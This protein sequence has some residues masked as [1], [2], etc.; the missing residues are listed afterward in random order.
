MKAF[1]KQPLFCDMTLILQNTSIPVHRAVLA[2]RCGYFEAMFRSFMPKDK[3]QVL[4]LRNVC[5]YL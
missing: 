4:I 1:L 5:Q 3:V 2:A